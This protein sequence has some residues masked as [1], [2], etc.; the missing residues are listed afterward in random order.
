[1][2]LEAQLPVHDATGLQVRGA[3]KDVARWTW[4][5][6]IVHL[7]G[8]ALLSAKSRRVY[9]RDVRMKGTKGLRVEHVLLVEWLAVQRR[10][11]VISSCLNDYRNATVPNRLV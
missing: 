5:G 3:G 4:I 2:N 9:V 7:I 8:A 10:F 1:M 6:V 11:I